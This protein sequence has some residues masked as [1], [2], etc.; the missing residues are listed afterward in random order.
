MGQYPGG[1]VRGAG[2]VASARRGALLG[3]ARGQ[4]GYTRADTGH[5]GPIGAR[6][7]L[8]ASGRGTR[9][10]QGRPV[11]ALP[12]GCCFE[13]HGA[14]AHSS[15]GRRRPGGSTGRA[16]RA[17]MGEPRRTCPGTPGPTTVRPG[18]GRAGPRCRGA[19]PWAPRGLASTSSGTV[20][21]RVGNPPPGPRSK[22][23]KPRWRAR[24]R[25]PGGLG[26]SGLA[27]SGSRL[28]GATGPNATKA[29]SPIT[30]LLSLKPST[31]GSP[32]RGLKM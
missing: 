9:H 26:H 10:R 2:P 7:A 23:A 22:R 5:T 12:R 28:G 1:S 6:G 15:A 31:L 13:K 14:R 21:P 11:R 25:R 16:R 20:E 19:P 27:P 30:S 18:L 17:I 8:G 29:L 24:A 32:W 4:Q 3:D